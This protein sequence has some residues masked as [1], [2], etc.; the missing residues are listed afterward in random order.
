MV[1]DI[2]KGLVFMGST[3][4]DQDF[5]LRLATSS[6]CKTVWE[7]ANDPVTR[8]ASFSSDIIPWEDH[9]NWFNTKLA[10]K[11][12]LF[13]IVEDENS[14]L[15]GQVRFEIEESQAI[16]SVSLAAES[17]G[18]GFASPILQVSSRKAFENTVVETIRAYIKP[19]NSPSIRAFIKANFVRNGLVLTHNQQA[20]EFVLY[21]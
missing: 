9:V 7:W 11:N 20:F 12:C 8:N 5:L 4:M 16:V 1:R 15:I 6:D 19:T 3:S 18:K 13:Y 14:N 17:R 10:D 21:R 2:R